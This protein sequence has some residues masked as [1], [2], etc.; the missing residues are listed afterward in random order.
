MSLYY[1]CAGSIPKVYYSTDQGTNWIILPALDN[2][3]TWTETTVTDPAFD[4]QANLRFAFSFHNTEG[5]VADPAFSID[6]IKI[7]GM[8]T[9]STPCMVSET[10]IITEPEMLTF[11]SSDFTN[12]CDGDNGTITLVA[13]GG[14]SPYIYN[15]GNSVD[16]NS[17]GAFTALAN[18]S[19]NVLVT[20]ANGCNNTGN[21]YEIIT[22]CGIGINE[23]AEFGINVFPNPFNSEIVLKMNKSAITNIKVF[24]ILGKVVYST[25][26]NALSKNLELKHINDGIYFIEIEI[27]SKKS[28]NTIIK[29]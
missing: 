23:L 17:T 15:I 29:N 12:T 21:N 4:N 28:I 2:K 26:F 1:L 16:S 27:D 14:T 11:A 5:S 7:F 20:D 25:S 18:G 6:E 24:D 3:N 22:D 19:Y 9:I 13:S 8:E 10:G